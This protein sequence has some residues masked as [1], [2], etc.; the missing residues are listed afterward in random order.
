MSKAPLPT[1]APACEGPLA[2]LKVLDLSRILAGPTCTQLLGDLG[3]DVVKVERLG[4]GDDTRGWGPPFLKDA[5]GRETRESAYYLCANRNKRSLAVDLST[6]EGLALVR[7]LADRSDILIENFKRGDLARRGLGYEDLKT[8]NVR[9][10]YCSITGFGQ[11]GPYADRAGYDFLIQGMG[12]IMSLTGTPLAE[13]GGSGP[14]KVGVGI[15][16]VMCGMY[17]A[18]AILAALNARQKNGR[19]QFIDLALLDSQVAWL[20]NQGLAHLTDGKVP[21]ALGNGHPTIVPYQ[22]FPA[23]DGVFILAVGNDDQYARFCS[24]AERPDL[25]EDPRFVRNADRVRH[26]ADLVPLIE[27]VTKTRRA[28]WWLDELERVGV[29]A[30]P[31]NDLGAVFSD[32]QILHRGMKITMPHGLAGDGEVRLIGNPLKLSGTPVTYRHPPPQVGEHSGEVL[33]E[34]LGLDAEAIQALIDKNVIGQA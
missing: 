17:A 9:L 2:G 25:A 1:D 29:P 4:R 32:P 34:R 12:G 27:Q 24:V 6:A 10:I 13:P 7:D 14:M 3:A 22:T 30:G 16:D 15:A 26:R 18:S 33:S 19:G 5:Q 8:R 11:D 23:S 28:G 31:V 21:G 20:I